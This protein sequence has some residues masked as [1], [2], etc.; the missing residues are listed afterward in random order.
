LA[1]PAGNALPLPVLHYRINSQYRRCLLRTYRQLARRAARRVVPAMQTAPFAE[2]AVA[3]ARVWAAMRGL[4]A[5]LFGEALRPTPPLGLPPDGC[6]PAHVAHTQT[7]L[8][9]HAHSA[10]AHNAHDTHTAHAHAG[11]GVETRAAAGGCH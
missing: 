8:R 4:S 9:A 5:S 7:A 1:V 11:G 3:A 10:H 2:R 6:A